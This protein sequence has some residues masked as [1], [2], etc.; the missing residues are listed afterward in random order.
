MSPGLLGCEGSGFAVVTT[1][2]HP[3]DYESVS[4]VN[5]KEYGAE[6]D[7]L[8]NHGKDKAMV[9]KRRLCNLLDGIV[10][11]SNLC[12][13]VPGAGGSDIRTRIFQSILSVIKHRFKLDPF[14]RG[15]EAGIGSVVAVVRIRTSC[16]NPVV[17]IGII[18]VAGSRF[19]GLTTGHLLAR[20]I[21]DKRDG[22]VIVAWHE[23]GPGRDEAEL[24][25]TC[26]GQSSNKGHH[27][28]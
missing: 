19:E 21:S 25:V 2:T 26:S 28:R 5:V 11:C 23:V 4:S 10:D 7:L 8:Q 12:V 13:A 24:S 17:D 16:L 18:L 3:M 27:K 9:Y 14:T 22:A 1:F 6:T 20:R 15:R